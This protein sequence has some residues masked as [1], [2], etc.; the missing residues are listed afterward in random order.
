MYMVVRGGMPS[1]S[2]N[3]KISTLRPGTS[4]ALS[5]KLDG[6]S[7]L[8]CCT[9]TRHRVDWHSAANTRVPGQDCATASLISLA[10]PALQHGTSE[11]GR[12]RRKRKQ[13][14]VLFP[15]P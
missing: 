10:P 7:S 13:L 8:S 12:N 2:K 11:T 15:E 14:A 3:K 9:I 5:I 4:D 6:L 1:L